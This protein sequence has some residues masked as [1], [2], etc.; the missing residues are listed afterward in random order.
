[1]SPSLLQVNED[2]SG[3]NNIFS[4]SITSFDVGASKYPIFLLEEGD[5]PSIDDKLPIL[6]LDCGI[7]CYGIILEH[8]DHVAGSVKGSLMRQYPFGQ[9]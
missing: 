8:V 7:T 2:I 3:F 5:E 4:T 9:N 6:S 1:M